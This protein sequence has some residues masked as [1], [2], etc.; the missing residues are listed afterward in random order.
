M[1]ERSI[2]ITA[3]TGLFVGCLLGMAGSVVPI[4]TFRNLT[5]AT[6][7]AGII[8][9]SVLLTVFYFRK[10]YDTMAAGFIILAIG[11]SMVF[12][13]SAT[14]LD[15]NF[16]SFGAGSLLWALAIGVLSLQKLFP[17]WVRFTGIIG[18][19]LFAAAS[20][21]ILTGQHV[22]PLTKPLPFL[23]YPFYAATLIGWAWSLLTKHSLLLNQKV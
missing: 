2:V 19:I 17:L 12:S 5:W 3:A 21:L 23:A 11:E 18:A 10:G 14:N 1:K 9:A 13:S 6:G 4:D 22:N 7:S 16:S 8:L 15:D 20:I